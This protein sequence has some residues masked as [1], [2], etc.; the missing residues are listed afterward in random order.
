MTPG[1][2]ADLLIRD[3]RVSNALNLDGD[4]STTMAMQDPISQSGR[5]LTVSSDNPL[6]RAVGSNLAVFAEATPERVMPLEIALSTNSVVLSWPGMAAGWM[7]QSALDAD[8]DGWA[9]VSI[10][11]QL[12]GDRFQVAL[13]YPRRCQYYRLVQR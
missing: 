3:Y 11:A 2:V 1:E 5:L 6:G 7:L 13:P 8:A 12:L 10:Q 9:D 4:G